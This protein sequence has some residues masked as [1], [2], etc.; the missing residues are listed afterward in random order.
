[1]IIYGRV[2]P[3]VQADVTTQAEPRS[4]RR[5]KIL[6]L[7]AVLVPLVVGG[8]YWPLLRYLSQK[9]ERAAVEETDRLDPGWRWE[10]LLSRRVA[11]PD[12]ENAALC[13]RDA[14]AL[15]PVKWPDWSTKPDGSSVEV[16]A[17]NFPPNARLSVADS[18]ALD[19]VL[20]AAAAALPEARK[21][22]DRGA[23]YF[24]TDFAEFPWATLLPHLDY[25]RRVTRL[26]ALDAAARAEKQDV[27]GALASCRA[28]L[29]T[30]R[31]IGDEPIV[32]S[33]FI[34]IVTRSGLLGTL[35]RVLAQ[36]EPSEPALAALQRLI[37]DE[38]RQPLL[39]IGLR[40]DRA[41]AD[42]F[43]EKVASGEFSGAQL[44]SALTPFVGGNAVITWYIESSARGARAALLRHM[45]KVIEIVKQP[46]PEQL[47]LIRQT[48]NEAHQLPL[49]PKR[50]APAADR[51][52]NSFLRT[53]VEL[54]CAAA[55]LAAER[56]RRAHGRWPP[57]LAA[58][59]PTYLHEAP[60]DLYDG[61]PLRFRREADHIVIY[62][63]GP[64]EQ[65][66]G[67]K[68]DRG[69]PLTAGLDVGIRL[70]DPAA[71]RQAARP[72]AAASEP[73]P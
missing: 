71:R 70:W 17:E 18:K 64:D 3:M 66:D 62:G 46:S 37:E 9:E 13:V 24:A 49:L 39:L 10:D 55:A 48:D 36:G 15:L 4:R 53:R 69:K 42:R 12:E 60:V 45:T 28:L 7:A 32:I 11:I 54:R 44:R 16:P 40:G 34:R 51:F 63:I 14:S 41:S 8:I 68:I 5:R 20:K 1:M 29:N 23:G 30:S 73:S 65:D 43:F 6:V 47:V 72:D 2:R 19:G 35:E 50:I 38:E 58:L 21:L 31:S 27:D 57:D 26:L 59:V 56:Y 67:G 52:A 25:I 33:Q 22:A 61:Q